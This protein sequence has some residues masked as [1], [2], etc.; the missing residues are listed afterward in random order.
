VAGVRGEGLMKLEVREE[1]GLVMLV[2]RGSGGVED[3]VAE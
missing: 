2:E 3:M 1:E